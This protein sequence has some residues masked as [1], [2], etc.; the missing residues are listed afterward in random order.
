MHCTTQLETL[1][2]IK[3][4]SFR[5]EQTLRKYYINEIGDLSVAS[6]DEENIKL[7]CNIIVRV[8]PP[9]HARN[10]DNLGT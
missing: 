2:T 6:S 5:P 9:S 1:V 10:L 7:L 4:G 8:E 3:L